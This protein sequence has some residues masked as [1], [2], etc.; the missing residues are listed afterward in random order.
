VPGLRLL[1]A[2]DT[3]EASDRLPPFGVVNPS[4]FKNP[5]NSTA[6]VISAVVGADLF[7]TDE[8]HHSLMLLV[9]C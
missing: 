4:R 5:V 7:A 2:E 3:S 1:N 6:A 8:A 9:D